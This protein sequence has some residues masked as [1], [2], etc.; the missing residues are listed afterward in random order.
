MIILKYNLKNFHNNDTQKGKAYSQVDLLKVSIEKKADMSIVEDDPGS[1]IGQLEIIDGKSTVLEQT[2]MASLA[3]DDSG[4]K[5]MDD[6]DDKIDVQTTSPQN[7]S[8]KDLNKKEVGEDNLNTTEMVVENHKKQDP[9]EPGQVKISP[10]EETNSRTIGDIQNQTDKQQMSISTKDLSKSSPTSETKT[11][12]PVVK[13][14]QP[15]LGH[16]RLPKRPPLIIQKT[17]TPARDEYD[18][19]RPSSSTEPIEKPSV[20]TTSLV[21]T[22]TTPPGIDKGSEPKQTAVPDRSRQRGSFL[23]K[24]S[25]VSELDDPQTTPYVVTPP[26]EKVDLMIRAPSPKP[27]RSQ[28]EEHLKHTSSVEHILSRYADKSSSEDNKTSIRQITT[29]HGLYTESEKIQ[30]REDQLPSTKNTS[31]GNQHTPPSQIEPDPEPVTRVSTKP[32]SR[33]IV[34]IDENNNIPDMFIRP[35]Q[36]ESIHKRHISDIDSANIDDMSLILEQ[37]PK[38]QPVMN[39]RTAQPTSHVITNKI[40][41][42]RISSAGNYTYEQDFEFTGGRL[43]QVHFETGDEGS[44]SSTTTLTKHLQ[45]QEPVVSVYSEIFE[46]IATSTS[47]FRDI[48][49]DNDYMKENKDGHERHIDDNEKEPQ[50][51]PPTQ[52]KLSEKEHKKQKKTQNAQ[53]NDVAPNITRHPF[54]GEYDSLGAASSQ[55]F[56]DFFS[57]IDL[58]AQQKEEYK[59]V[60]IERVQNG[61]EMKRLLKEIST[62]DRHMKTINHISSVFG[63]VSLDDDH[64]TES[65]E[66]EDNYNQGSRNRVIKNLKDGGAMGERP[67][68]VPFS[69]FSWLQYLKFMSHV[70]DRAEERFLEIETEVTNLVA[71]T[72]A[73][74]EERFETFERIVYAYRCLCD[75]RKCLEDIRDRGGLDRIKMNNILFFLHPRV[76]KAMQVAWNGIVK[77]VGKEVAKNFVLPDMWL[78]LYDLFNWNSETASGIM[79]AAIQTGVLDSEYAKKIVYKMALPIPNH[80]YDE[81]DESN[82][83]YFEEGEESSTDMG[84]DTDD[85]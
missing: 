26:S 43:P 45:D 69:Y 65:E 80:V 85:E 44:F 11:T 66:Y 1:T 21:K 77:I 47:R 72:E 5:K 6:T 29:P 10:T 23:R 19:Q 28:F 52:V 22:P 18:T 79:S 58:D 84:S 60:T 16:N 2:N 24:T 54:D 55:Q 64:D 82:G 75:V 27:T 31:S 9:S 3:E 41:N 36:K 14:T 25:S 4:N 13:T 59:S 61:P 48:R 81:E 8:I 32:N 68:V 40:D 62:I 12:T 49:F 42:N 57:E 56:N 33:P 67:S 35:S 39:V 76:N 7:D 63:P 15:M 46:N 51:E 20:R 70:T 83:E 74:I 71:K 17:S 73:N 34:M 50:I 53:R 30:D 37:I 38:I 78:W